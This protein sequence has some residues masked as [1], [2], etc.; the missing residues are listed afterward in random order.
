MNIIVV[1]DIHLGQKESNH[2]DFANFLDFLHDDNNLGKIDHLVLLGDILEFWRK[3]NVDAALIHKEIFEKLNEIKEK[4]KVHYI[5]GNHDYS[6]LELAETSEKYPFEVTKNW[7]YTEPKR[8]SDDE[9][10]KFYFVHGYELE[11]FAKFEPMTVRDY[12]NWSYN[13]C[14]R[15]EAVLGSFL[16]GLWMVF[17]GMGKVLSIKK[18]PE[19][20]NLDKVDELAQSPEVRSIFL[21]MEPDEFL[22]FGHTHRPFCEIGKKVANTGSW[23]GKGDDVNTFVQISSGK[24]E[25]KQ[26]K[27]GSA[28]TLE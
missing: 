7:R 19:K 6:I 23:V 28:V 8:N 22:L 3:Q 9:E 4:T 12:E 5:I 1:S 16:S 27:E 17:K 26:W 24:V 13:L 2:K 21:G 10:K 11:V 18:P 15:T 25:L 14:V 20:R